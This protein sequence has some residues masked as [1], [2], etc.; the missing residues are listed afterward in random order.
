MFTH[1]PEAEILL[2]SSQKRKLLNF[3]AIQ[4]DKKHFVIFHYSKKVCSKLLDFLSENQKV[5]F[6][7]LT[8]QFFQKSILHFIIARMITT[9]KNDGA[10]MKKNLVGG[11]QH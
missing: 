3:Q 8:S 4:F 1:F 6:G 10:I 5:H 7:H 11:A 2:N 9:T